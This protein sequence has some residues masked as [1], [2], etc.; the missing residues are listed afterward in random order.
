[1]NCLT[2]TLANQLTLATGSYK[3]AYITVGRKPSPVPAEANVSLVSKLVD[4]FLTA[5][6]N[7][8]ATMQ[9]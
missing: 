9:K 5:C 8:D 2:V 4:Y 6:Q 3:P 7:I 1:M